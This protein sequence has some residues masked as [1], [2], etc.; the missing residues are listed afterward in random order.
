VFRDTAI[1]ETGEKVTVEQ[2]RTWHIGSDILEVVAHVAELFINPWTFPDEERCR[3][4][5][6]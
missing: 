2:S 5:Q 6:R 3:R 1:K 4:Q